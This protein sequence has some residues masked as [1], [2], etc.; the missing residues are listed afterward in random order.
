METQ[1]I[2]GTPAT[3]PKTV[4]RNGSVLPARTLESTMQLVN[5]MRA[6]KE[7]HHGQPLKGIKVTGDGNVIE[8]KVS[9]NGKVQPRKFIFNVALVSA[10]ALKSSRYATAVA[11]AQAARAE[12]D[13]D[14]EHD[15]C[16][17]IMNALT[18]AFTVIDR[19]QGSPFFKGQLVQGVVNVITTEKGQTVSVD[20]VTAMPYSNVDTLKKGLGIDLLAVAPAAAEQGADPFSAGEIK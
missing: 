15:A 18:V 9:A 19:G 17:E 2:A 12:G 20:N 6:I 4:V 10:L 11:S 8:T 13:I 16:Q 3:A 1:N 14:K 7:E 5:G